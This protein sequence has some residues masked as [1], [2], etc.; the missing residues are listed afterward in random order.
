M[1]KMKEAEISVHRPETASVG[2]AVDSP[3]QLLLDRSAE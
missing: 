3:G 2:R 1:G